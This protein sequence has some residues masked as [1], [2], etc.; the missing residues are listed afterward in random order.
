[1]G[2]TKSQMIRLAMEKGTIDRYFPQFEV[3]DPME[4][5]Y[6]IGAMRTNAD[7]L[8]MIRMEI[9]H[10]YPEQPPAVYIVR[11]KELYTY[12][13][14]NLL[15]L[16]VSHKMHTFAPKNKWVQMCL[17]RSE[18]W[19]AEYTLLSCLKKARLWLEAYDEHLDTGKEM[20]DILGTQEV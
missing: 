17:Y 9:P 6:W 18:Y 15:K 2:W 13:G 14:S 11:P 5:T 19:S 16:G 8:Y 10:Q 1:M 7:N 20:C 12:D 4:N 3:R